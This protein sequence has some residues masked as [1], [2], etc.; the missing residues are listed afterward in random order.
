MTKAE[1]M[2]VYLRQ[3]AR[4]RVQNKEKHSSNALYDG[5]STRAAVGTLM[6]MKM[7]D[8]PKDG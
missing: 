7:M 5:E 1:A 6:M 2:D 4:T 8:E 3:I